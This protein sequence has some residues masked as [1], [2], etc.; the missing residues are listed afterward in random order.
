MAASDP[1]CRVD[2][3]RN[4]ARGVGAKPAAA[5]AAAAAAT[6]PERAC[7]GAPTDPRPMASGSEGGHIGREVGRG[8]SLGPPPVV[9]PVA[10]PVDQQVFHP[11]PM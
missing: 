11:T 9:V 8:P 5:V 6:T 1:G 2:H 7:P 10:D 3:L 4:D